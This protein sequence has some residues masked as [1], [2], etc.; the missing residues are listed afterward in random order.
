MQAMMENLVL[1]KWYSEALYENL[2][3][4]VVYEL[5]FP[6]F[7]WILVVAGNPCQHA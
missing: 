2:K 7:K 4:P 1:N 3:S 6:V 5:Y